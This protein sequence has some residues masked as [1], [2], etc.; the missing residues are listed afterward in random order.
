MWPVVKQTFQCDTRCSLVADGRKMRAGLQISVAGT[1]IFAGV[2]M[3]SLWPS[4]K[5]GFN[6]T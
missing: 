1:R 2:V 3:N 6:F 5:T 4:R